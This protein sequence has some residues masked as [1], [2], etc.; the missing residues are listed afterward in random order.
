MSELKLNR[1]PQGILDICDKIINTDTSEVNWK[2]ESDKSGVSMTIYYPDN[3]VIN[4]ELKTLTTTIPT[5]PINRTNKIL[6]VPNP[7]EVANALEISNR[8]E[9]LRKL[10]YLMSE[11]ECSMHADTVDDN[12]NI[13]LDG[14][15]IFHNTLTD[16][17][18]PA[19]QLLDAINNPPGLD[20]LRTFK[21]EL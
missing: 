4:L 13:V 10:A 15:R 7:T 1:V 5:G 20:P 17:S 19:A 21:R 18:I 14:V 3:S 16:D 11:Y 2:Y 12:I 6:Q 9:F 8:V